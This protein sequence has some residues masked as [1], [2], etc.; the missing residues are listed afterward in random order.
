M[1]VPANC[2]F[3]GAKRSQES[4]YSHPKL[5][6]VP[7]ESTQ[8]RGGS[9]I[10]VESPYFDSDRS[11]QQEV[12]WDV[13]IGLVDDAFELPKMDEVIVCDLLGI[14]HRNLGAQTPR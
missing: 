11:V 14:I 12:G 4:S 8:S 9:L 10:L 5:D 13:A 3:W 2:W 6:R 1:H 7:F